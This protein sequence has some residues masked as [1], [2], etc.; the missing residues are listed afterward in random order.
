MGELLSEIK[1]EK[2]KL[3]KKSRLA[4]IIEQLPK[5]QRKDFI[6][7]LDDHTISAS[8]IVKVLERRGI[9]LTVEIISRYRRGAL[10]TNLHEVQ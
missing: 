7:A 1:S 8:K 9:K 5:D 4:E 3:G 10:R 2:S 6:S